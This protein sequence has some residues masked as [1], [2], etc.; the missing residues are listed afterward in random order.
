MAGLPDLK[1]IA[2]SA[3]DKITGGYAA[4]DEMEEEEVDI[5]DDIQALADALHQ[6]DPD[7][8]RV[9][10]IIAKLEEHG[11]KRAR[12]IK[13]AGKAYGL[14]AGGESHSPRG[15]VRV[16]VM[17]NRKTGQIT[18]PEGTPRGEQAK[19]KGRPTPRME[20]DKRG[21]MI[22]T[23][24]QRQQPGKKGNLRGT[25]TPRT[26]R[27]REKGSPSPRPQPPKQGK[28]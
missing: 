13:I 24:T 12:A 20:Q 27:S 23:P 28:G 26:D 7:S 16:R 21:D 9:E 6:D 5:S 18:Y 22:G 17:Y 15:Q 3:M 8:P 11:L 2:K 14:D 1:Q 19:E 10:K 4:S 25:V